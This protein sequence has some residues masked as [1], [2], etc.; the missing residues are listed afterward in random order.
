MSQKVNSNVLL[1][2]NRLAWNSNWCEIKSSYN[3]MLLDDFNKRIN[4]IST[5]KSLNLFSNSLLLKS[6]NGVLFTYNSLINHRYFNQ[7]INLTEISLN[8]S[9]TDLKYITP[10]LPNAFSWANNCNENSKN[11]CSSLCFTNLNSQLLITISIPFVLSKSI[12]DFV[13]NQMLANFSYKSNDFKRGLFQGIVSIVRS[14]LN[15]SNYLYVRGIFVK[16]KGKW[17]RTRSGR[18]Q[19][20]TFGI[21][22]LNSEQKSL[23][24]YATTPFN[25]KFGSCTIK[26]W[27]CFNHL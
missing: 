7:S 23:T 15:K 27:I 22:Q 12:A 24:S 19:L 26:V 13:A 11:M 17:T 21:G 18:K 16:C 25:T 3:K 10:S 8:T 20:L 6:T 1:L 5:I 14:V 4:A 2:G 9:K